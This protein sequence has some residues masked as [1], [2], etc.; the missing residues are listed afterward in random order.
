MSVCVCECLYVY[1]LCV[2]VTFYVHTVRILVIK[3]IILFKIHPLLLTVPQA[4]AQA[5]Q[6]DKQQDTRM[7]IIHKVIHGSVL[8]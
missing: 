3:P 7:C 5:I 6:L 4:P 1:N 2:L 8:S